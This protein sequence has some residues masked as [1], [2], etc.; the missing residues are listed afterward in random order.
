[1]SGLRRRVL[2]VELHA[3]ALALRV[4]VPAVEPTFACHLGATHVSNGSEV[5]RIFDTLSPDKNA[6]TEQSQSFERESSPR[7]VLNHVVAGLNK[8][9]H[10][11][12]A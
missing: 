4:D 9:V 3:R 8:T 6:A 10:V 7:R 2:R 1:M 12:T 5:G 11:F